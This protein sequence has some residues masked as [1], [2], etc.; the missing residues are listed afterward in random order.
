MSPR[1]AKPQITP[2]L[3]GWKDIA[4]YLGKG[5]RTV[6]R[7][8]RLMGLPI[9]RPAGRSRGSVVAT[10]SELDA[11]VAASP[12]RETFELIRPSE[13]GS[14]GLNA[15]KAR[16]AQMSALRDE[17]VELRAELIA[18]MQS[19]SDSIESIREDLWPRHWEAPPGLDIDPATSHLLYRI[20]NKTKIVPL[21]KRHGKS[22]Q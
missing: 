22:S 12:I 15:I 9:R 19:L 3:S 10:K 14:Y 18:S 16:L 21:I 11:W 17:M 1:L 4:A 5:V 6:Q 20:S 7:Y 13:P 8:E 2:I